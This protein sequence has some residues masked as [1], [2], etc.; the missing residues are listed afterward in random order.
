VLYFVLA[1]CALAFLIIVIVRFKRWKDRNFG[2][3][4]DADEDTPGTDSGDPSDPDA[5]PT[6]DPADTGNLAR[7]LFRSM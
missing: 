6:N 2:S 1:C 4:D 5:D 7:F 3:G